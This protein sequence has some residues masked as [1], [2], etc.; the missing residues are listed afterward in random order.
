MQPIKVSF[1]AFV[2]LFFVQSIPRTAALGVDFIERA[3]FNEDGSGKFSLKVDLNKTSKCIWATKFLK[4]DS[5][6]KGITK[7]MGYNEGIKKFIGHIVFGKAEAQLKKIADI[8]QVCIRYNKKMLSFKLIFN[9]NT[10][11]ALNKAMRKIHKGIDPPKITYFSI[12]NELFVR[13][14]INGIA[15]KILF[16]QKYDNCLIKSLDLASF[17]KET[18]YTT[19]YT[20]YREVENYSNPLS[21]LTNDRKSMRITHHIFAPD[22]IEHSIGNR[23]HFVKK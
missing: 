11:Q 20:F 3:Y 16:Y 6:N 15:Q 14:D 13:Q 18:T 22:E 9:F 10:I 12:N 8:S 2:F 5:K 4:K 23:I 7:F 21:E 1:I 17:F 19:I